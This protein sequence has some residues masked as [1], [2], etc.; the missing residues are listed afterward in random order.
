MKTSFQ[1]KILVVDPSS[2][3]LKE[4]IEFVD[5]KQITRRIL[6]LGTS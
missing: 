2:C 6:T 3:A 5:K 4:T 1:N